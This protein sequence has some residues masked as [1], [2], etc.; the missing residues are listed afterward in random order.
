MLPKPKHLGP[1]FA[2]VFQDDSVV[3]AYRFR[4]PYPL[5]TIQFLAGL[6]VD[7]PRRVLDVGCGTGDIARLLASFV[8]KIDAV[9]ISADMIDYGT[10]LQ[11]GDN[12][13]ITWIHGRV[14]ET[15]L[16][17][18]YALITAG[19]SFHWMAWDLVLAR[20]ADIL[21]AHGVVAIVERNWEGPAPLSDCLSSLIPRYTTNRDYRP[22]DLIAE[23]ENRGLFRKLGEQQSKPIVW[24]PSIDEYIECRH[25]QNGLSHDR[26][27]EDAI[28]FD[29]ALRETL[30]DLT[31]SG[32]IE[33]REDLL[34]LSVRATIVWG[35]P[36][37]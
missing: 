35:T 3:Y 19:E 36:R 17:D 20:F 22:Y 24:Q 29:A 26:M 18:K 11:G 8:E 10:R 33:Q 13:S 34:Q 21:A 28:A 32:V 37:P 9:D 23:L 7:F 5:E 6:A 30:E 27:G 12:P 4:P 1:E 25:S 2:S 15:Q 31:Q 14:E 16:S